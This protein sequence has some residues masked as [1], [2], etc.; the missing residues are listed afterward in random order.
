MTGS[1][2]LR[3]PLAAM[4]V[5]LAATGC[6]FRAGPASLR[7]D[8]GG[9]RYTDFVI[10]PVQ[11]YGWIHSSEMVRMPALVVASE[12]D[13]TLASFET[14]WNFTTLLVSAYH[15]EFL[16]SWTGKV[17]SESDDLILSPLRP[18]K[19][20]DFLAERGE[21]GLEPVANH[22]EHLLGTY[23]PAFAPGEPRRRLR[24]YLPGL[25]ALARAATWSRAD[26]RRW[27]TEAEA[28]ED[29]ARRLRALS[30]AMQ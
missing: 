12:E 13:L 25:E 14:G 8:T 4:A 2:A 24:R 18:R 17:D 3:M 10:E 23:V 19:W 5:V 26:T 6:E 9:E 16:Y 30:E 11:E 7:I 20:T 15:P 21:I 28:R 27:A 22:L 29:L 1:L